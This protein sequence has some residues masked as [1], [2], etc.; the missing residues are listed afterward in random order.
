[1]H[2][3]ALL[4]EF[5]PGLP[6]ALAS[7]SAHPASVHLG[8]TPHRDLQEWCYSTCTGRVAMTNVRFAGS[9]QISAERES[10]WLA[11]GS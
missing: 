7:G 1:M 2:D 11:T 3:A 10:R 4:L 8:N 5:P 9:A 6:S